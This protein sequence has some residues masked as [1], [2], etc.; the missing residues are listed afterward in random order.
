MGQSRGGL[1]VASRLLV[2]ALVALAILAP[3]AGPAVGAYLSTAPPPARGGLSVEALCSIEAHPVL[4]RPVW[5]GG[6]I[7]LLAQAGPGEALALE[8]YNASTGALAW[9]V[10]LK[11]G[12][13]VE[14][15]SLAPDG[16]AAVALRGGVVVYASGGRVL[17]SINT[18]PATPGV[19]VWGP[20]GSV[21]VVP[22][23]GR[24]DA[25]SRAGG[26]L[27][28]IDLGE[29]AVG[30]LTPEG[31][32]WSPDGGLIAFRASHGLLGVLL[33]VNATT[34]RVVFDSSHADLIGVRGYAWSPDGSMLAVYDS[35]EGLVVLSRGGWRALWSRPLLAQPSYLAWVD[36]AHLV[37]AAGPGVSLYD[38]TGRILLHL[39]MPGP[40]YAVAAGPARGGPPRGE[41]D[42]GRSLRL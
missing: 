33:V 41:Q 1:I 36:G 8:V 25:Y 21:V 23:P 30:S 22:L 32:T 15:F 12:L 40:D 34:G 31:P 28:S 3:L 16:A 29:P 27:W 20:R 19:P 38:S 24:V 42:G 11:P 10:M 6:Y 7:G 26:R 2:A 37:V 39:E 14:G 35:N 13:Q 5:G 4:S 17:W 9:R 18:S